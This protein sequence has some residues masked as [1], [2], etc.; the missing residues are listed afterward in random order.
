MQPPAVSAPQPETLTREN[1]AT[2][3]Y[4]FTSGKDSNKPTGVVFMGGFRSNMDGAKALALESWCRAEG[5]AYLRFDYTGHGQSSGAFEDG[6]IG[7]WAADALDAF[8]RLSDGPQVVVG[9]SM[10]GWLALLT[11]RERPERVRGLIGLAAAPDFTE[12]LIWDKMTDAQRAELMERGQYLEPNDYDPSD[13][14]VITKKLIEDGRNHLVLRD[15]LN[16]TVPVR[17]IQGMK[18][19]DV[20]WATALDIQAAL[21]SDDVEIQFAKTSDHRLSEDHDLRRLE[22]TLSALLQDLEHA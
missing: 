20:P 19:M 17:L 5:R 18:D 15:P 1:G 9:S 21:L 22:R 14:T 16:I 3:A 8:D 2:I 11:A 12:T 6:C 13:P 10:G 7:D 4:H